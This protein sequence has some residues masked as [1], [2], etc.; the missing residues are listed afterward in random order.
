[1][2]TAERQ[3]ADRF[4]SHSGSRINGTVIAGRWGRERSHKDAGVSIWIPQWV[5]LRSP[6]TE[7]KD[8]GRRAG[9]GRKLI[10]PIL[11]K[12]N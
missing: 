12:F 2:A 8:P 1:M 11:D 5:W 6:L 7:I 4:E 3:M 9:L 10:N